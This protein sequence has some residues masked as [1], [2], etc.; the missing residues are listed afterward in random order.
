MSA[1]N[2]DRSRYG[3]LR[4]AKLRRRVAT[5]LRLKKAAEAVVTEAP[6]TA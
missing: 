4:K 2:G 5:E 6:K 1:K 3:R